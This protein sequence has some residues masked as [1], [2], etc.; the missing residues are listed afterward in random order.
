MISIAEICFLIYFSAF[1]Y[2]ND[3]KDSYVK[4]K[5]KCFNKTCALG[6]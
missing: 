1:I 5:V 2:F 3:F 6:F 4:E